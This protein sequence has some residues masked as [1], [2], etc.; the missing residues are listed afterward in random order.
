[1]KAKIE[2]KKKRTANSKLHL[3]R[4][5]LYVYNIQILV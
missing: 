5:L 4:M 3:Y 1:M 2:T